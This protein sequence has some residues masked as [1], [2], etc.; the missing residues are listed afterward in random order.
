MPAIPAPRQPFRHHHLPP[1]AAIIAGSARAR[2]WRVCVFVANII[3]H[4]PLI[5]GCLQWLVR[6]R[7][8]RVFVRGWAAL[9]WCGCFN[10]PFCRQLIIMLYYIVGVRPPASAFVYGLIWIRRDFRRTTPRITQAA[11]AIVQRTFAS[12]ATSLP[13]QPH[14]LCIVT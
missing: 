1:S 14:S 11:P 5:A 3:T 7:G 12:I 2:W 4:C 8:H 13:A 6:H 10:H 9:I